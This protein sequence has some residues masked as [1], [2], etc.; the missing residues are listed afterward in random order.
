MM[1]QIQ[2]VSRNAVAPVEQI[3]VIPRNSIAPIRQVE[4][5]GELHELGELRDFR[6]NDQLRSF[7]PS[8]FSVSWVRLEEGEVLEPHV[9]PILSMMVFYEGS[10][11]IL[12]DLRRPVA[13]DDVVV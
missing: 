3:H 8:R 13:K 5:G 10:G 12:G 11:E 6:W 1:E 7:M 4:Q 9:H 2:V